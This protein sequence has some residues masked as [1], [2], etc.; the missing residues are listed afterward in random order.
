MILMISAMLLLPAID[1]IAKGLAGSVPPG[2]IAWS[3][4]FFQLLLLAPFVLWRGGLQVGSYLWAH[5]ARGVLIALATLCFFTAV[6]VMPLADA[7][8]VFFVQPF[9]VTLLAA[10]LLGET[11]GWR[12]LV[13]IVCGFLGAM[14]IIKP[15]YEVFGLTALLPVGAAVCF[16]LYV[17]LTRWLTRTQTAL[18]MQFLA[19]VFGCLAMSIALLIGGASE[20]EELTPVWPALGDWLLLALL[21]AIATVGHVLVVL[22]LNRATIAVLAPFQYLEIISATLLGLMFFGDFPDALTW[23]GIAIIVFSGLYVFYRE[24]RLAQNGSAP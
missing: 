16:A 2:Q 21:G 3:R 15:S 6:R 1:A 10:V 14:L 20:V 24:R 13:A 23:A 19:G 11:F 22:A 9:I 4:F 5:A 7:I 18:G 17:I 12:R 8:A